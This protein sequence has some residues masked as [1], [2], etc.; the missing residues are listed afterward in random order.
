MTAA[1]R[2]DGPRIAPATGQP[3]RRLLVLLHGYGADGNDLIGLA[4]YWQRLLPDAAFVAP[5]GPERLP[6]QPFGHQW[7]GLSTYDPDLLRRDPARAAGVYAQMAQAAAGV[8]PDLDAFIDAELAGLGLRDRDLALVGFSQG[9]MM[10]LHVGLRRQEAC[11]AIVGFSGAL[12]G[13]PV[14]SREVTVRPPVLLLHGDADPMVPVS[15][16]FDAAAGLAAAGVAVEWHVCP[17]IGHSIDQ[18]GLELAGKFLQEHFPAGRPATPV[19][20]SLTPR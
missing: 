3:A 13:A 17:G 6:G 5:H 11:A 18:R 9:T 2:L 8:A 14:L 10:A 20:P 16:M 1:R 4:P 7:F 19:K 15:A 12:L